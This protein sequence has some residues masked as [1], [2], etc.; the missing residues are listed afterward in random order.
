LRIL[1]ASDLHANLEA[2]RSLPAGDDELWG[3]GDT[4]NDEPDPSEVV[5]FICEHASPAVRGNHDDAIGHDGRDPECSPPFRRPAA[6]T[7]RFTA[8]VVSDQRR[9]FLR[10]LPFTADG[11]AGVTDGVPEAVRAPA[12]RN[13]THLRSTHRDVSRNQR[14]ARCGGSWCVETKHREPGGK[15]MD[16]MPPNHRTRPII[17][18]GG[19]T[20]LDGQFARRIGVR[21]IKVRRLVFWSDRNR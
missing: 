4:V 20:S 15:V 5:E 17:V 19:K 21:F 13:T 12:C 10:S 3:Q 16:A 6:E 9:E 18:T 1:V 8:Y 14:I 11:G 7:G 2:V